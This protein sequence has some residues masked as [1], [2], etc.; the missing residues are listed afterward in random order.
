[1]YEPTN[2]FLPEKKQFVPVQFGIST[3]AALFPHR[4]AI[5]CDDKQLSFGRLERMATGVA[6]LLQSKGMERGSRVAL[7][8]EPGINLIVSLLAIHKA[9]A[10]FIPLSSSYPLARILSMLESSSCSFVLGD[11]SNRNILAANDIEFVSFGDDVAVRGEQPFTL[12]L[13]NDPEETAYIHFTSGSTGSP[14]GVNILHRNLSYYSRWS[15]GF[16]RDAVKNQLP[17]TSSIQFAASISQI[18]STLAAGETLHILPGFLNNPEKLF[19]W[20]TEHPEFGFYCVPTVWK[21]ALDWLEKK[22]LPIGGPAALFLSG[23]NISEVLLEESFRRFPDMEIWN[24]YGPT[25]AVAN[26]SCKKISTPQD[27]SLGTPL[28]GTSFYVVK[29]DGTQAQVGEEGLL[30]AAGP[31][32]CDGYVGNR[33]LTDSLFFPYKTEHD[34]R[35]RV[36]NTG[37]IV[38]ITENQEY[39][40]LGRQD[41]QVKIN[42]QRIELA[43]IENRL[44]SHPQILTAVLSLIQGKN[45]YLAAYIESKSGEPIPVDELRDHLLQFVTE[46]MLPE[47]W[48]F[49]QDFPK[50]DNGKI[51]R[52]SLSVPK[53]E[54]PQLGVPFVPATGKREKKI[55]GAFTRILELE[56]IGINDSFFDLGGNSLKALAL[57]I[58]IEDI[59]HHRVSFT[60]LFEYPS[61]R[62][63]LKQIPNILPERSFFSRKVPVADRILP[64]TASQKG[65]LLFQEAYQQNAAYNIAYSLTIEGKLDVNR[66]KKSLE[67]VIKRHLPLSSILKKWEDTPCFFPEEQISLDL[68]VELLACIPKTQRETFVCESLSTFAAR[69]FTLFNS[70]LYR[71]KL[72]RLHEKKHVL[73]WVVHHLVF[74][75]ESMA[76]FLDDLELMYR[77]EHP[78]PLTTSYADVVQQRSEYMQ[79]IAFEQD[80]SFWKGYLKGVRE[81]HSFPRICKPSKQTSFQG[82]RVS[83]VIDQRLREKMVALCR[84]QGVTLNTVLMA[85]FVATLHKFGKREEYVLASPF[86]NR[87]NKSDGS[88]IGYFSNTLLYRIPCPSG[89]CFSELVDSI[90]KDTIQMLDHQHLP[91]DQLVNIL[92]Q[93]GMNLPPS[94]FRTLF[95]LHDTAQWSKKDTGL[96]ITVQELFNRYAKCDLHLECFDD[97]H[98]IDVELTFAEDV[99]DESAALQIVTVFSQVLQEV[100]GEYN[101]DLASLG[102]IAGYEKEEVLRASIADKKDYGTVLTLSALIRN[103]CRNFSELPAISFAE[104]V[105]S[106]GVL[107]EKIEHCAA[108]LSTLG[109]E[110][111][112]PLGIFLDNTPELIIAILAAA[113]LGHPYVP[114]DP[115]YPRERIRYIHK[116]AEIHHVLITKDLELDVFPPESNL[117]FVDEILLLPP[118]HTIIEKEPTPDDLLYIIY[119]SGSTGNPKG[120]MLPNRG[121]ANYLLWM[122]NSFN[123]GTDTK[124]LA[125]TSISFDISVWELFLPLI[126]GGTL[127]LERRADIES[128]EQTAAVISAKDV[129]IFQ[130][131]P[132]GLKL[133]SDAGM[134]ATTPSLKKIFC[135]GEKLVPRLRDDV[136][137][138]FNGDLYNLYGP[139]EASI[140]M[141]CYRC[142]NNSSLDRVSIGS[143]IPNSSLYVLDKD[144]RL[145][146]RNMEGDLYIGGDVLAMGYLKEPEKTSKAFRK[147][148]NTLPEKRLYATGDRGRMLSCGKFELLG[149]DDYQVKI[150]GYR[151]ELQEVDRAVENI[152]G[153]KQAVTYMNQHSEYD[154]RLHVVV[155]PMAGAGLLQDTIRASLKTTLPAY[156]IPSSITLVKS[157]PLLPNGKINQKEVG[158]QQVMISPAESDQAQDS[159]ADRIEKR[160]MEIWSEVLGQKNFTTKDNFFDVGGHSLLFL[161]IKDLIQR[162]LDTSFSIVELY[163][164]PNIA[165][166]AE[167][168]KNKMGSDGPSAT[169]SAVRNRISRRIRKY[170]GRK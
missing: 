108:Y 151:V 80:Y 141:S 74:D 86:S 124:I 169:V 117:I 55:V 168:Y 61:P 52:K 105:M 48:V 100:S 5:I 7:L 129:N 1:M 59:F 153:V 89:G 42:G 14:K 140:F 116:H 139:T 98:T 101:T 165:S 44:L 31:G 109:L 107:A 155:V 3:Q 115:S 67:A 87:L 118:S 104:E 136:L 102:A 131:V 121:V 83:T 145:L 73:A 45:P 71:C 92:R 128:P 88:M 97:H 154:A 15:V 103:S 63:L 25:E 119:T 142:T 132:S 156:M 12:G 152:P 125:K 32:I 123:I 148:P 56:E 96:S 23:E 91:F 68:P 37:D 93:Q 10:A 163:Q 120:V 78:A 146:P 94:I 58:E 149:R 19:S 134:F 82:R 39:T 133:F 112:E 21:I 22:N 84:T 135:G 38:R 147:S 75:G 127:C 99:I 158:K 62:T 160:I 138:L 79:S 111:G 34:D 24:L 53:N 150:R 72:Y 85:A 60:T 4:L 27:C 161:K 9:G 50:L 81:F 11:E 76:L 70:P 13:E 110:K 90:R 130:F 47:R 51:D 69:P 114:L 54:R 164:Y 143:P 29:E 6:S 113:S 157:I 20:Y 35:V 43:E 36:Y 66:L 167:Q 40:F 8:F 95:A 106:Y 33:Q 16:F 122:K 46:A 159:K 28:P 166:M 64:L 30:H 49:L 126:A 2:T 162:R 41:Q 65:L 137:S 77:G 57:L 26:L 170:H 18:Y 17:L 144:M